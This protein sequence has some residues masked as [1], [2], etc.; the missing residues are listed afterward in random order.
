MIRIGQIG[1]A[2]HGAW[3]YVKL[4][5]RRTTLSWGIP[6]ALDEFLVAG[7]IPSCRGDRRAFL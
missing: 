3:K 1:P 6:R 7:G 4:V 5:I 2:D